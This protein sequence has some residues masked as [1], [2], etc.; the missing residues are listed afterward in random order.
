MPL[1]LQAQDPGAIE[2]A[3]QRLAAGSLVGMPTETV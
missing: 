2:Q 1:L 3:S